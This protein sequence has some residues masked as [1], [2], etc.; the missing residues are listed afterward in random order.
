MRP[1]L[2][3]RPDTTVSTWGELLG[4]LYPLSIL[5]GGLLA[6][7]SAGRSRP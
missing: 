1:A 3:L 7:I 2:L 6:A 4:E 5:I